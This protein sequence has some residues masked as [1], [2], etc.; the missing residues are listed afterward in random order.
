MEEL[1][2]LIEKT[3]ID[4]TSDLLKSIVLKINEDILVKKDLKTTRMLK[5]IIAATA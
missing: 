4:N 1:D 3:Q 5:S 2:I